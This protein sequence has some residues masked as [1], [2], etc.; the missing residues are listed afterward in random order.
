MPLDTSSTLNPPETVRRPGA[1]GPLAQLL[2]AGAML[3]ALPF[4]M[5]AIRAARALGRFVEVKNFP[6]CLLGDL[7][8]ALVNAQPTLI[9]DPA[10]WKEFDRN[11]FYQC[12]HREACGSTECL[13]LNAGYV[14]CYGWEADLLSPVPG[15]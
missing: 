5:E 14:Q 1:S 9:I 2:A 4:L 12:K 8:D 15:R 3:V 11:G 6:E 13:G 7:G 10:F